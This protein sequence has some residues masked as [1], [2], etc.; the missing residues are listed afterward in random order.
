LEVALSTEHLILGELTDFI[1]GHTIVDTHDERARQKIARFLVEQKGY[2]KDHIETRRRLAL[3][4]DGQDGAVTVDFVITVDE[5]VFAI[6]MFG[7][8]SV[9]TRER[10][11]LAAARLLEKQYAVPVAVVTNGQDAAVLETTT[12][13]VMARGLDGIPSQVEAT[14]MIETV[15]FEMMPEERLEKEKRILFAFEV[16]AARECDEFTCSI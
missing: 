6:V 13:I 16:L 9:V 4:L 15:G 2:S 10:S 1:T 5:K 7:P 12:G 11:T 8:G 14:E 3:H